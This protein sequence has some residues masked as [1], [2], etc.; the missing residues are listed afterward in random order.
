[1]GPSIDCD[2]ATDSKA[3]DIAEQIQ[4]IRYCGLLPVWLIGCYAL[5][6]CLSGKSLHILAFIFYFFQITLANLL[7][8]VWFMQGPL[9]EDR[10]HFSRSQAVLG[11]C[12]IQRVLVQ[13]F[14]AAHP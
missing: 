4:E 2:P 12:F 13:A 5:A 7:K 9:P 10:Q 3:S 14:P 6:Y 1:L 11:Q 8:A